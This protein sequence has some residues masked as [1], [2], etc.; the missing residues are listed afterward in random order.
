MI[1]PILSNHKPV[2]SQHL[3]DAFVTTMRD[4]RISDFDFDKAL[5]SWEL[6]KG[7]PVIHVSFTESRQFHITQERYFTQKRSTSNDTSSWYIPLNFATASNP[8]FDDTKIADF[9]VNDQPMAMID[10]PEQFNGSQ[11][12]VFNKQQLGY[13]RVNYDFANWHALILAL[14]S[15]EHDKIHVLNRVQLK[16]VSNNLSPSP[17]KMDTQL[18]LF[19]VTSTITL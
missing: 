17:I 14:N 18:T 2:N 9:F 15:D 10:A 16:D 8:D 6:Q 7:H 3:V 19:E 1:S 5:R 13:Y 4:Q 12:Y 11:W